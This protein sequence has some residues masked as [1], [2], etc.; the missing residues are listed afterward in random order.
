MIAITPRTSQLRTVP[1]LM[2]HTLVVSLHL[3]TTPENHSKTLL[4]LKMLLFGPE[5]AH[6]TPRQHPQLHFFAAKRTVALRKERAT[7]LLSCKN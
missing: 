6:C 4:P 5:N 3:T 7:V 2:L 1:S